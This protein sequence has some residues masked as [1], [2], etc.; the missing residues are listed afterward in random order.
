MNTRRILLYIIII[1]FISPCF[2]FIFDLHKLDLGNLITLLYEVEQPLLNTVIFGV[3]ISLLTTL[4]G[5]SLFWIINFHNYPMRKIF[6]Y[7]VFLPAIIPTYISG[8]ATAHFFASFGVKFHNYYGATF[9]LILS[10]YPYI[11]LLIDSNIGKIQNILITSRLLGYSPWKIYSTIFM[12]TIRPTIILGISIVFMETLSEY[13]MSKEYGLNNLTNFL[14]KEWFYLHNYHNVSVINVLVF[15]LLIGC[16]IL[17][18]KNNEDYTASLPQRKS[19]QFVTGFFSKSC[20][21][22]YS[23]LVMIFALI[24]PIGELFHLAIPNIM[25][26]YHSNKLLDLPI[27]AFNT[28]YLS[29]IIS[30][31]TIFFGYILMILTSK[32]THHV[33][34]FVRVSTAISYGIPGAF[35]AI[36]LITWFNKILSLTCT[37]FSILAKK[38]NFLFFGTIFGV[39]YGSIFRFIN[40]AVHTISFNVR[41]RRRELTFMKKIYA[42]PGHKI[43]NWFWYSPLYF[44]EIIVLFLIILI[45][46]VKEL[47]IILILRPFNFNNLTIKTFDFVA[48]ERYP[49]ASIL[50]LILI[51]MLF[52][53]S[54]GLVY[55]A[56]RFEKNR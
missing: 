15:G 27:L 6:R 54:G 36:N 16:L 21:F 26:F 33:K 5:T 20:M 38:V 8:Y 23:L 53:I 46:S 41:T 4:L 52:L 25:S 22:F 28:I 37:L 39:I 9:I 42:H 56:N 51:F 13:G 40:T 49:E 50:A 12:P 17:R 55:A 19:I 2:V 10:L 18:E 11:Y 32:S 34:K 30:L 31:V 24:I 47:P 43:Y 45:D 44:R 48:D 3:I 7:L 1:T 14:Y 35:I 29:G